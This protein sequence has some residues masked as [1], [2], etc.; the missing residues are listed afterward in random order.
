V[1]QVVW[2]GLL[3]G[4]ATST[5]DPRTVLA[6]FETTFPVESNESL[7]HWIARLVPR[8]LGSFLPYAERADATARIASTAQR[9]IE[10]GEEAAVVTPARLLAGTSTDEAL[11]RGWV[12]GEG[13]PAALEGDIEF[14]WSALIRLAELGLVDDAEIDA[15]A[16]HDRTLTGRQKALTAKAI[17]PTAEAKEWAWTQLEQNGELSNYDCLAIATG[18]FV[19]PDPDLVR[20]H[21]GRYFEVLPALAERQGEFASQK[22]AQAAFPVEV[23]EA[24]TSQAAQEALRTVTM[25]ANVRRAIV[26]GA[27]QLDEALASMRRFGA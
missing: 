2:A 13:V 4:M 23:T 18:V 24:A 25:T 27:A 19:A 15:F 7:R 21:V 16:E 9:A 22:V 10:A 11:L 1:R 20:P 3:N 5:V 12:A 26:D 14:R 17:R 8:G 6:A